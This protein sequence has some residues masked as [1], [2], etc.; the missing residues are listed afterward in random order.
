MRLFLLVGA[1]E[2]GSRSLVRGRSPYRSELSLDAPH[3][4]A[5]FH[6]YASNA[7][8]ALKMIAPTHHNAA[9]PH[10]ARPAGRK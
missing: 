2:L 3:V 10:L 8:A 5:E 1:I 9:A 6:G 7:P 4:Q